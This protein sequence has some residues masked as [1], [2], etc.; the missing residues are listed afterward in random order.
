[1]HQD[2]DSAR[3]QLSDAPSIDPSARVRD[4]RFG[5]FNEVGARTRI[6]E[7]S[8]G[9]YAYVVNDSDIIYTEIGPFCSIAAQVRI[10]PGNHP[11]DR[12][13]L[14]HF[15]Y[16][17]SAYGL[18]EDEAGFFDW[19]R[20]KPVKLGADAW[21]GHGAIILPGVTVGIGAAIGAGAVVTKDVPDYAIV[22]GNPGRVLRYRFPPEIQAALKRIAWWRWSDDRLR[23][24]LQE[25]RTLSAEEFCRRHDPV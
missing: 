24:A 12:V 9:D 4:C 15:T 1:M 10:N 25:I 19:R 8:M 11:L 23:A 22:V 21:V 20:S 13:A 5:R 3:K 16:R 17:A 6:A 7:S 14:S 18:G 2:P